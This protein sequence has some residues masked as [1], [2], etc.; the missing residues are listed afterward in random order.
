[1]SFDFGTKEREKERGIAKKTS[2]EGN[3]RTRRE[4]GERETRE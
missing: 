2:D 3:G 1:L 4:E